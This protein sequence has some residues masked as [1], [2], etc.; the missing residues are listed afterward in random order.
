VVV[1]GVSV[2]STRNAYRAFLEK[3]R[4][5]FLTVRER[6]LHEEF[7]TFQYPETYIISADGKVLKKIAAPAD[8][9]APD[10]VQYFD[11]LLQNL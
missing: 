5:A 7:G 2:D 6:K 11:G 4:P 10:V 1:L 9:M 3:Y 8:W